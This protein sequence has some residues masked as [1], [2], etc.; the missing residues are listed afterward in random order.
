[1]SEP[2]LK[3]QTISGFLYKFAERAGAK[4]ISFIVSL[5][6]ARL[7]LPSEYGLIS[8]VA[9]FITICDVFVTYGFGNS[10]IVDK[11]SDS[12]DFSTCF[13]F[14]IF[15]SVIFYALIYFMAP[16]LAEYYGYEQITP[17]LRV[18]AI[19]IPL[20]A[21]NSVQHAYVSKHMMFKK[22]FFATSFGT[23]IS[24]VIAVVMA[25]HGYGVWALVEQY[26]GNIAMDTVCLFLICS[27]RPTAEFSF[28][29][30][31]KI[32]SYGWKILIVGLIDTG[33][34]QLRSLVIAKHYT[35]D[36]LAYY[37][38]GKSFPDI[39]MNLI[40]PT[41]NG[42]LFPALSHCKNITE[43]RQISKRIIKLSGYIL[44]PMLIGLA[45]T[46]K[47]LVYT[48]LTSKWDSCVVFLQ[49]TCLALIFRPLQF[50]NSCI[51][52]ASGNS[53]LLLKLDVIKKVIGIIFLL[54][55]FQY[56]VKGIAWSLVFTNFIS[57][58][59]NIA[60]NR[61]LL[62]YGY[63]EQFLDIFS[64]MYLAIVMGGL[65]YCIS[66]IPINY[67]AILILQIGIGILFYFVTSKF[68][69][70]DSFIYLINTFRT[71]FMKKKI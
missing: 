32:Y 16:Y 60:P 11:E 61:R 57:V 64:S 26:I 35:S 62:N 48:L 65:V 24:G 3:K 40:E 17:V 9:I 55:G 71:L 63:R 53:S 52:K 21:V 51:I 2:N 54:I 22:F 31:K 66:F 14:G 46:A 8:L 7:L 68:L 20:A 56:G 45:V 50:I 13:Y 58:L 34:S 28:K 44:A 23:I 5:V 37:S 70:N 42:V 47:P 49:I 12:I 41:I 4:G 1:M 59:I 29:K 25:Y 27:W 30:L 6:L 69:N 19:R 67:S 43:M 15:L 10:L 18:M 36:D 33:Y 38:R 39:A